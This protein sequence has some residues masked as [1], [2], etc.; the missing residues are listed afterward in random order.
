MLKEQQ[1]LIR[2][3]RAAGG[4]GGGGGEPGEWSAPSVALAKS[5]SAYAPKHADGAPMGMSVDV[6]RYYL[7]AFV[8]DEIAR[9]VPRLRRRHAAKGGEADGGERGEAAGDGGGGGGGRARA[10]EAKGGGTK[11]EK[12][13][14]GKESFKARFWTRVL[15][16]VGAEDDRNLDKWFGPEEE[17]GVE[18]ERA[19]G[20][21][22]AECVGGE[23]TPPPRE[24]ARVPPL[25]P[26]SNLSL[27]RDAGSP[28]ETTRHAPRP[29]FLRDRLASPLLSSRSRSRCSPSTPGISRRS[30]SCAT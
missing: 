5:R 27:E 17:G 22:I 25:L 24:S 14:Q 7:R 18:F 13:Q 19:F 20:V 16:A 30:S 3:P 29:R 21:G 26:P 10:G 4:G 23:T 8:R 11:D 6:G 1:P 15:G 28:S 9:Y 2:P 12:G